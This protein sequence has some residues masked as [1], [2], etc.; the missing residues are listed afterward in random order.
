MPPLSPSAYFRLTRASALY[1]IVIIT[2]FATPWTFALLYPQ[3]SDL[4]VLLGGA[5]L[6]ACTPVLALFACLLGSLVLLWSSLRLVRTSLVLGRFD[7][8]GRA[9]FSVWMAWTLAQGGLPLLWCYLVPELLWAA[10][11]A[12]PVSPGRGALR[13]PHLTLVSRQR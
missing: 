11:Q 9:V 6:P 5:P 7:A 8:T 3:L 4:N 10:A 2:P 1:D 13:T 12:W